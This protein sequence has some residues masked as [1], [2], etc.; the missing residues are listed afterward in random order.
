MDT[1]LSTVMAS[2][3]QAEYDELPVAEAVY[4]RRGK[5]ALPSPRTPTSIQP[6]G[7]RKGLGHLQFAC[8]T[9]KAP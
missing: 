3:A 9:A 4:L 2:F 6:E 7:F 5:H 1:D 8:R